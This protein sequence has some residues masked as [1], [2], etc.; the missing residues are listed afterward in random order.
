[1]PMTAATKAAKA[2]KSLQVARQIDRRNAARGQLADNV[3]DYLAG[4][5][6]LGDSLPDDNPEECNRLVIAALAKLVEKAKAK[7]PTDEHQKYIDVARYTYS[8]TDDIEIDD[9][10]PTILSISPSGDDGVWVAAWVWVSTEEADSLE[11]SDEPDVPN[12]PT[13]Q[14]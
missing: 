14:I 9:E 3:I 13:S 7:T 8:T 2:A 1:M 6:L 12:S 10:P 4:A 5:G 11:T